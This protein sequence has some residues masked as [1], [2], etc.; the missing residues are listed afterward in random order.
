MS[1]TLRGV[2][3]CL[4][5]VLVGL[6]VAATTFG[7]GR[8]VPW[9]PIM[10]DL[11]VYRRA[12]TVLLQGGDFYTLPGALQFLYPPVAAVLAVPLALLPAALAQVGWTVAGVLALLAVLHRF[13]LHSWVLSLVGTATVWFVQPVAETL[14]FGQLGIF[15][16]ALVVLDLVPGPRIG[17]RRLLPEGMLTALAAAV[18]LTPALFVVQLLV[19]RRTRAF[20][21]AVVTGMVLTLASAVVA[22]QASLGFWGR[23][24]HGDASRRP[25]H[26]AEGCSSVCVPD[27]G[28]DG[29]LCGQ[30]LRPTHQQDGLVR[31][32]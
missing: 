5:P 3:V 25:Q 27:H 30:R 9:R 13:G 10:V 2:A 22:P 12:G 8:F 17:G 1:R 31:N 7:G 21:T 23:L 28:A 24:A 19:V 20:V 4:L 26:E 18:K 14:A 11:D 29:A 32:D 15:L 16:V 6:Y